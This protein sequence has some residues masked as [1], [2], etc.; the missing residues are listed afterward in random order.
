MDK[1]RYHGGVHALRDI[2]SSGE[3][4]PVNGI[5]TTRLQWGCPHV[6]VDPVWILLPH[7]L[8]IALEILGHLPEPASAIAESDEDGLYGLSAWLSGPAWL[9]CEVGTRSPLYNR[10][11]ELRCR[12]GIAVLEDSYAQHI[13]VL[14]SAKG[15]RRREAPQWEY[16]QY[17]NNMPLLAEISAFVAHVDGTGPAPKSKA[18][19]G[20]Q[21]VEAISELRQLAGVSDAS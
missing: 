17:A 1:W 2:A 8:S 9:Q 21:I 7:D 4:G 12:D 15:A 6:D 18:T 19:E 11:V 5:K 16:R 14:H 3:L 20:L 10:R 13:S